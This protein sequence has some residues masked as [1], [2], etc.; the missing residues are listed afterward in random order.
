MPGLRG[1]QFGSDSGVIDEDY[2][3]KTSDPGAILGRK[4]RLAADEVGAAIAIIETLGG[5]LYTG[6]LRPAA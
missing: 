2:V 1:A 4:I 6:V 5:R 3:Q